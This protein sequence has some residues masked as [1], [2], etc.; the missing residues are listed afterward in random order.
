M[1]DSRSNTDPDQAQKLRKR[2]QELRDVLRAVSDPKAVAILEAHI[3]ELEA[4]ADRAESAR[5]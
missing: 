5:T 2:A 3:A 4:S 1:T